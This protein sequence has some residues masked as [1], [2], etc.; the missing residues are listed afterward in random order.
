MNHIADTTTGYV[1]LSLD[2]KAAIK[3][4]PYSRGGLNRRRTA[5]C[6]HDFAP[7]Y[8][9]K[10]FG[11]LLPAYDRLW[12]FFTEGAISPDFMVDQLLWLWPEIRRTYHPHALV[13][14]MDNGPDTNSH[15][16]QLIK[17][18]VEF[19]RRQY[20]SL[21]LAYYPPYHSKYN[22]IE[23]VWGI[24]ENHWNG[25]LLDSR[26]KVLDLFEWTCGAR[27]L[28]NYNWVGGVS[29][30]L[31]DGFTRA[32][33]DLLREFDA[34]TIPELID[35]II[36]NRIFIKRLADVGVCSPELAISYDLTGPN[37]RGSGA[38]RDVPTGP[39]RRSAPR[40]AAGSA[41]PSTRSLPARTRPGRW[42]A[43][44]SSAVSRSTP[45]RRSDRWRWAS[46][47][48]APTPACPPGSGS[49]PRCRGGPGE[50]G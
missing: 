19:A 26:E 10:L 11:I 18:L 6:D 12:F 9:L 40:R 31:P 47:A 3:V 15:R 45:A 17:R 8:V 21:E 49:T 29:H 32:A 41:R 42:A 1:R 13:L 44:P 48:R 38:A 37:L 33:R 24:V 35:L 46:P 27:L 2:A 14:N 20:V 22:A 28:Y 4:G 5:A 43:T 16:T 50:R 39:N 7:E 25:E 30:D 23:R 36:G 34:V